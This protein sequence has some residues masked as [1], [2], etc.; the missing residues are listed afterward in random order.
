MSFWLSVLLESL[1]ICNY[2]WLHLINFAQRFDDFI[3]LETHVNVNKAQI[4][5]TRD[6]TADRHTLLKVFNIILTFQIRDFMSSLNSLVRDTS[7]FRY[8][9]ESNMLDFFRSTE[10]ATMRWRFIS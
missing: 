7:I 10:I 9:D 2:S 1:R 6:L 5:L 4:D 3:M 8:K